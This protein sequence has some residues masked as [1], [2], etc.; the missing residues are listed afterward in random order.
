MIKFIPIIYRQ[1]HSFQACRFKCTLKQVQCSL[2]ISPPKTFT[3]SKGWGGGE[4]H[5]QAWEL[6]V[7][8]LARDQFEVICM[9]GLCT[10][11]S[12]LHSRLLLGG[13]HSREDQGDFRKAKAQWKEPP[14][15]PSPVLYEAWPLWTLTSTIPR[16]LLATQSLKMSRDAGTWLAPSELRQPSQWMCWPS[17]SGRRS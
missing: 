9:G 13:R 1:R 8:L 11:V 14:P 7:F 6:A 12:G 2:C 5:S 15:A 10:R 16:K 4:T 17:T 3:L